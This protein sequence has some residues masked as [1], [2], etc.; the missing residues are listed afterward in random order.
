[1]EGTEDGSAAKEPHLVLYFD[2]NKVRFAWHH[3]IAM[4]AT[5]GV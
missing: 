5:A 1:M 4:A 3:T 2:V